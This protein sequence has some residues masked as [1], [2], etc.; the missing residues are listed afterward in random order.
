[1]RSDRLRV[2]HPRHEQTAAYMAL[3]A[4]LATGKPQA[5]CVVPG[6]GLLNAAAPLAT[7]YAG[8]AGARPDRPDLRAVHRQGHRLPARDP[9]P[10]RDHA[11]LTKWA[12]HIEDRRMQR[13]RARRSR[14][15]RAVRDPSALECG[16][17][18][19]EARPRSPSTTRGRCRYRPTRSTSTRSGGGE[20]AG[21]RQAADHRGRRRRP[22]RQRRGDALVETAPGAGHLLPPRPRRRRPAHP[23]AVDFPVGHHLWKDA[24]VVLAIGTRSIQNGSWGIDDEPE[25][26]ADR[27]RSRRDRAHPHARRGAGRRCRDAAAR[28][29]RGPA[30]AQPASAHRAP[31]S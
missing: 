16:W 4:A 9:R 31:R 21:R 3:G 2:I 10:A 12:G 7:A 26:R 24:D 14:S 23:F 20:T 1:M 5:F 8:R 29:D 17:T 22:G 18:H 25:G 6:P 28:A 15:C 11:P 30:R 19:G 27:H 13:P